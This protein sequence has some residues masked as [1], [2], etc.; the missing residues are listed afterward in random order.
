MPFPDR[1]SLPDLLKGSVAT[2][3][4]FLAYATFPL[5]GMLPG[6]FAPFP[7][8]FYALKRGMLTGAAIVAMA[9]LVLAL[10]V[11]PSIS[12][13]Y[14]CQCGLLSLALPWFLSAGEKGARS[15]SLSVGINAGLLLL[16]TGIF[17]LTQG[18]DLHAQVQQGIQTSIKQ[19]VS[20]YE[21]AGV[22]GEELTTLQ[23]GAAEGGVLI[24]R[25]YPALIVLTLA[26][27]AGI[28][29]LLLKK[30][31]H[32]L[33]HPPELGKFTGF[34][35]PEPLVWVMIAA[36]FAM[37]IKHPVVTTVALNALVVTVALYFMQ[38]MAIIVNFYRKY[39]VPQAARILFYLVL[40]LQPY[41]MVIVA[42]LGIFDIW[43][44]FRA[45]KP[46]QNL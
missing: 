5:V 3:T 44:N 33:P 22:K 43:G 26:I 45:P 38:G 31:S 24:G 15:I 9:A 21:K 40:L 46:K 27:I 37:L 6:I 42:A 29:T 39:S 36:G 2:L 34:K 23:Q 14:F 4:L 41:L 20:L 35:N 11:G 19:M 1:G 12:L 18:I 28:N 8:I 25:I 13:L 32:R 17:V 10:T 30:L 7:A 16:I